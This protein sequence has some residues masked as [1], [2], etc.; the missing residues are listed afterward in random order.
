MVGQR[1]QLKTSSAGKLAKGVYTFGSVIKADW[2]LPKDPELGSHVQQNLYGGL[3][4]YVIL[5]KTGGVSA[6]YVR[7]RTPPH[8][9]FVNLPVSATPELGMEIVEPNALLGFSKRYGFLYNRTVKN[10]WVLEI[11]SSASLGDTSK[12]SGR[13]GQEEFRE[14]IG[15]KSQAVLKYAWKSGDKLAIEEIANDTAKNL[16]SEV[17]VS[18]GAVVINVANVWTLICMLLLRDNAAGKT[19]VCANPECPAPY[20]LK[21]RKTQRICEAGECVVWAQRN[22]ALK[23]W[24]ENESKASKGK[25]KRGAK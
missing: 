22:Y 5:A 13:Y 9:V 3:S 20:F 1:N 25:L 21:S 15:M 18:T 6:D 19:A 23:W 7:W 12:G 24:R 4:E 10:R 14:L 2:Q 17:D 8:R 11:E 16:P